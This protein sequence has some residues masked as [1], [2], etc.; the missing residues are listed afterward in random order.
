MP[1]LRISLTH[2]S[3]T[4]HKLQY[5]RPDGTGETLE[6]ETKSFLLH[7]LLH[8]AVET[9]AKLQNSFY[10]ML[11]R[12]EIYATLTKENDPMNTPQTGE[13]GV[14]ERVVGGLT[15]YLK[16]GPDDDEFLDMMENLCNA[17]GEHVPEYLTKKFLKNI[18]ERMRKLQGEWSSTKFGETMTLTFDLA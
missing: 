16:K 18:K 3:P 10:G 11:A 8:F 17:T 15:A 6:L 12:G 1:E 13:I 14:T 4:H 9:E 2:T 5:V 7:D